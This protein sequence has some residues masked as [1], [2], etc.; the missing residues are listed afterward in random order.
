MKKLI[1]SIVFLLGVPIVSAQTY[2]IDWY[3]IG[4][5]G[6]HSQSS[7]YQLD[8][9]IGQPIVGTSSS[10]N[11]I[12]ESGFW[13]GAGEQGSI[14]G[15]YIIGDYNGSNSFNVADII[16]GFSKL[17]IGQPD[18]A[19]LCECPPGSG[20]SWAVAMDVNNSCGFNV[21]DII[22][23]FSKLRTGSPELIPCALCPPGGRLVPGDRGPLVIPSLKL[24]AKTVDNGAPR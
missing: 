16:A 1:C 20:N 3:V 2:Q 8:G 9:T 6:G 12:V 15:P 18:P 23:A 7:S 11:Y 5:G 21:A 4:S 14:C 17:K 24:K 19:L 10:S 22:S 13:V